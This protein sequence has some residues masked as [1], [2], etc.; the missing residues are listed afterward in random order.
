MIEINVKGSDIDLVTAIG[1]AA[2]L[3][4]TAEEC[5]ELAQACLK[6][7]RYYRNENPAY[8]DFPEI[9]ANLHEEIC[10]VLLCMEQLI[11]SGMVDP[12]VLNDWEKRKNAR[13]KARFSGSEK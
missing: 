8:K 4:Q 10:D 6:Y 7:A 3:E 11:Q 13:M 5:S 9:Y 2:M 1:A 12:L